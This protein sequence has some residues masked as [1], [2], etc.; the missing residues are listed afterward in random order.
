MD[1]KVLILLKIF[2]S[3]DVV[4]QSFSAFKG[5]RAGKQGGARIE[6]ESA[7]KYRGRAVISF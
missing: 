6:G 1:H 7:G 5:L 2:N 4:R 3:L